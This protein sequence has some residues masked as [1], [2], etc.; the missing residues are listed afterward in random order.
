M[1]LQ[2]ACLAIL[3]FGHIEDHRMSV[4]LRGGVSIDRA[5]SVM[6]EFGGNEFA[7]GFG[8]MIAADAGLRVAFQLVQARRSNTLAMRF[9]DP[10]VA[11]DQERSARRISALKKSRPIRR[12]APAVLMVFPSASSY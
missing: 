7:G 1:W 5:G 12:D 3:P 9:A 11:A 4:E 10:Y 8:R 6:L 2:S